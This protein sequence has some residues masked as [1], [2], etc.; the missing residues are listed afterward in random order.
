MPDDAEKI[1]ALYDWTAGDCFRC[2]RRNVDTTEVDEIT[3]RS[4]KPTPLRACQ[5]CVLI[6]ERELARSAERSGEAYT[7]GRL[8]RP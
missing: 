8:R 3:P 7:P 4:G 1:L 5:S 2:A 6:L